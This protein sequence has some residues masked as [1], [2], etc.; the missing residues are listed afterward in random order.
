MVSIAGFVLVQRGFGWASWIGI[1]ALIPALYFL[2]MGM[3]MIYSSRVGKVAQRERL[4]NR[5]SWTGT[6][7]V[8]D[9]GCGRGLM[10]VAA[11]RRLTTGKAI[12][13]DIWQ[14]EDQSANTPQGALQ[15]AAL[16][17]VADRVSVETADI[18][19]LPYADGSFDVVLSHWVVHNIPEKEGREQALSELTRVLSAGGTLIL[20]DIQYRDEYRAFLKKSG[21][22]EVNTIVSP[23]SDALLRVLTFGSFRP[24]AIVARK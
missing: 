6:E 17:G 16:E 9:A 18:R 1:I 5:I 7:T 10:L 11:A 2:G 15:N 4:L 21:F 8:L 24:A 13:V 19:A 14:A 20:A 22:A 12:G 3:Y 23:G